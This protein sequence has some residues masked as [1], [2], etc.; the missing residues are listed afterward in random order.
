MDKKRILYIEQNTDGTVGGSHFSLLFLVEGLNKKLYSPIAVFYQEHRLVP[1]YKQAG[2][3]VLLMK[4][5]KTLNLAELLPAFNKLA[6]NRVLRLFITMPMLIMQKMLNYFIAFIFPAFACWIIVIKEKI[7]LVHLNNTLLRPQQWILASLFTRAKVIAHERGINNSFPFQTRFW[8]RFLKR[9]ICISDA[10]K[11]N[12]L[13]HGFSKEKL[14]RIYNGLDPDKFVPVKTKTEVMKEFGINS[15]V[16][17]IGVVGNVKWWKGQ[18]TVI[19]S[20]KHVKESF[21]DSKCLII[22]DNVKAYLDHIKT[23]VKNENLENCI[24]FTGHRNDIPDLINSLSVLIHASTLPEPFGRVLLE[25]MALE[26]PIISTNIGA[27]PEIIEDGKTGLLVN[28]GDE[29]SLA[30]AII[31]ML[32][33]PPKALNMGK[34]GRIR[35]EKYFH[36]SE[37]IRKTEELYSEIFCN[38]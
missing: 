20:M 31:S 2:C 7:D 32:K 30:E 26:K 5:P 34:A 24:I 9:I 10:V 38:N 36:I 17:I 27:G 18:E 12:L 1:R 11:E 13:K 8:A 16:P 3:K 23:I 22:G 29:K 33:D 28:P 21:P 19:R 25:G 15:D 4:K 35:L 14:Y 6:S 37:N